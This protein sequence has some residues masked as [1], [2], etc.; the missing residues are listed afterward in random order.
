MYSCLSS[1]QPSVRMKISHWLTDCLGH[2]VCLVIW[3]PF[4]FFS[5]TVRLVISSSSWSGFQGSF[6]FFVYLF[7]TGAGKFKTT[8]DNSKTNKQVKRTVQLNTP[9]LSTGLSTR[10][11]THNTCNAWVCLMGPWCYGWTGLQLI[12]FTQ[13]VTNLSVT[14]VKIITTVDSKKLMTALKQAL[15]LHSVP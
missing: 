8:D 4:Y 5:I 6:T 12:Q 14:G 13:K 9:P 1:C 11:V 2:F 15:L 10:A 7:S 3:L